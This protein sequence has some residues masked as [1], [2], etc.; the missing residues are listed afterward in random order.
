MFHSPL[1]QLFLDHWRGLRVGDELPTAADYLDR[2][3]PRIAPLLIMFDCGAVD[4]IIRFQGTRVVERWRADRT[5]QSWLDTKPPHKRASVLANMHD[6]AARPCGVWARSAAVA[7]SGA[8]VRQENLTLP[9]AMPPDR[10]RRLVLLSTQLEPARERDD[11]Y[12][13]TQKQAI[14]WFDVGFGTPP[15][16]LRRLD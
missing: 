14:D 5:G 10:A 7:R 9:L 11:P 4:V 1:T 12:D 16:P 6:C 15:R 2:I 13:H 8:A 3:D